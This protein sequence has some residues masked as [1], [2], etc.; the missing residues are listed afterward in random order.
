M[1]K[2]RGISH[3][4]TAPNDLRL[5]YRFDYRKSRPNR[6]AG[7]IGRNRVVVL[8]DPDISEVFSTP[9]SVNR[10]LRALISALPKRAMAKTVH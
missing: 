7:R 1:K 6:F 5:G 9:A 4:S 10:A 3:Q 2:T 8:L